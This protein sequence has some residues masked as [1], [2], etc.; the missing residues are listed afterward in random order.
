MK[1][2]VKKALRSLNY[3]M[4]AC[5]SSTQLNNV[6]ERL[7]PTWGVTNMVRLGS[8]GDGGYVLSSDISAGTVCV[9]GGVDVNVD[10]EVDLWEKFGVVCHCYD[11]SVSG[12]PIQSSGLS[13][14][15]LFMGAEDSESF[16]GLDS[17]NAALSGSQLSILKLDIE[18]WE[19]EV[20]LGASIQS[21]ERFDQIVMELHDLHFL[22]TKSHCRMI[23]LLLTKLTRHFKLVHAVPNIDCGYFSL[24]GKIIPHV[25]EL[26]FVNS[27]NTNL[28]RLSNKFSISSLDKRLNTE[29][30]PR[31]VNKCF[32]YD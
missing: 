13:F 26:T 12:L 9:S 28:Q 14:H 16:R 29:K 8:D 4:S 2:L 22:D 24:H 5:V 21:L 6:L 18:G 23:E 20:L 7:T 32:I 11:A 3:S 19:Y 17:I 15:S 30:L 1:S 27:K 25:L 10:F 31:W